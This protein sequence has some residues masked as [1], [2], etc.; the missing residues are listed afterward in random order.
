[1]YLNHGTSNHQVWSSGHQLKSNQLYYLNSFGTL[2]HVP[3][4]DPSTKRT[5]FSCNSSHNPSR[6]AM[7][8]DYLVV[9]NEE[10]CPLLVHS[11]RHQTSNSYYLYGKWLR[12]LKFHPDGELITLDY[13]ELVCQ[14][15]IEDDK[16]P[17]LVW[18]CQIKGAYVLC[19]D[20]HRGLAYVTGQENTL[21]II[22]AGMCI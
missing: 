4:D 1:M 9:L 22:S 14:Y 16:A 15:K 19:V 18:D 20:Q 13:N 7:N 17:T 3:L 21:L 6:I 12:S 8:D 5:L 2:V 10:G 11:F